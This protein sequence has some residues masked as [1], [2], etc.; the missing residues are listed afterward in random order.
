MCIVRQKAEAGKARCVQCNMSTAVDNKA[1]RKLRQQSGICRYCGNEAMQS[2]RSLRGGKRSAY[3]VTCY[4]KT[5]A[6]RFLGA[7]DKWQVLVDKLYRH[8]WRCVYTGEKLVLGDSLSFDHAN[9]VSR[10]PEQRFQSAN[11]EPV[12]WKVNL[13]KRDLTK[14][15]FLNLACKIVAHACG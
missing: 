7:S 11:L 5:M 4:L 6:K 10:F 13:L 3:C 2:S 12:S 8:D 9:P 1:R 14:D 15:E